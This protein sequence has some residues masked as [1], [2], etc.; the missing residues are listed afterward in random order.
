MTVSVIMPCFNHGLFLTESVTSILNQTF[1][2]KELIIVDDCSNDNSY[3][4]A[5]GLAA[6]DTRIIVIRND[7]N[8]GA[9]ASRNN[10]VRIAT[11][12]LIAF[13]DAD[14]LWMPEKLATQVQLLN[15]NPDGDIVYSDALI[16]NEK[17]RETGKRFSEMFHLPMQPSGNLFEELCSRNFV[18]MQTVLIRKKCLGDRTLFDPQIKW[19]ED[20]WCWIQLSRNHRFIYFERPLAKYRVHS[21]STNVIQ[22]NGYENNRFK[23]YSRILKRFSG[24][25]PSVLAQIWYHL[26]GYFTRKN[27]I[28]YSRRCYV[29]SVRAALGTP[30][31]NYNLG[32]ALGKL[33]SISVRPLLPP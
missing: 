24:L 20:W 12:D 14:D 7:S 22:K 2:L 21:K 3:D 32:R 11:G 17:G 6:L 31:S 30:V 29:R 23:V 28:K 8:S 16:I 26:G 33:I 27:W 15:D 1:P 9:S 25:S 5:T 10:G 18:N 19:V 4:C 13:C